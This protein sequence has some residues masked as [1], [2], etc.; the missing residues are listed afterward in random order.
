MPD[1]YP[2]GMAEEFADAML[3]SGEAVIAC[4]HHNAKIVGET[5][6]GECDILQCPDCGIRWKEE[7]AQ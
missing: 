4:N 2:V 7:I 1:E 5:F 6:D 3:K